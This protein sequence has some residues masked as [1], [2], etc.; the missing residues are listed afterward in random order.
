MFSNARE[1]QLLLRHV[2]WKRDEK[3]WHPADGRQWKHFDLTHDED[4]LMIQGI[5]DLVLASME[6]I[7]SER[8]ETHT[9][10]D[11]LLCAYTIFHHGCATSESIFYWHLSY[12]VL[13]S[14]HWYRC[15]L[16]P[17]MEDMQKLW[18]HGV[19]VWDEYRKEHFNLNAIIFYT[20]NDN[21]ARLAL[22]G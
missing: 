5:L 21:P 15:F 22:T 3:I 2:Q 8:W 7:L 4:F 12:L 20:I 1:A 11:Q 6:W 10:P 9:V 19:N 14:W 17:L 16:E 13:K 18:E